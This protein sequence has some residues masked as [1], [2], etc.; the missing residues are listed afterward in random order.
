MKL[1]S[2]QRE[3]D[4]EIEPLQIEPNNITKFSS[5]LH[6]E[7]NTSPLPRIAA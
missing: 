2:E 5:L 6:V 4:N 3:W 7:Y 1:I